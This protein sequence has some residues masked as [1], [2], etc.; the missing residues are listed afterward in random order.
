[1]YK[2][3]YKPRVPGLNRRVFYS[4]LYNAL[5]YEYAKQ[6]PYTFDAW[7]AEYEAFFCSTGCTGFFELSARHS[8]TGCTVDVYTN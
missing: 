2:K 1:M 6:L 4:N 7:C 3:N 8:K 5:K